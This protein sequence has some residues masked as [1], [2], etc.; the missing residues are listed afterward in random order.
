[1]LLDTILRLMGHILL[2]AIHLRDIPLKGTHR[3]PEDTHQP[4]ILLL[5]DTH[6]LGILPQVDTHHRHI[7]LM[8]DIHHILPTVDIH[9][10]ATLVHLLPII[11]GM[12]LVWELC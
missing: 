10:Q 2:K 9:Q 11:Q 5:A 3:L 1:M 7:L 4:D 12:D 6:P 8:V